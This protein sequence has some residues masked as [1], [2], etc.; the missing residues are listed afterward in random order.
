M[1]LKKTCRHQRPSGSRLEES[2]NAYFEDLE[3][4]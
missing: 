4:K 3:N 2:T 1:P